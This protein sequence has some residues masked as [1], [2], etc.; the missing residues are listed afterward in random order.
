LTVNNSKNFILL[1]KTALPLFPR[2]E[3]LL[4]V[5]KLKFDFKFFGFAFY[6]HAT[7]DKQQDLGDNWQINF[8]R[9]FIL[10]LKTTL[11]LFPRPMKTLL[12]AKND[13][14]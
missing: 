3:T 14:A 10:L 11:P 5:W 13:K 12:G 1:L 7:I 6:S 2:Y 8:T 9:T 4:G